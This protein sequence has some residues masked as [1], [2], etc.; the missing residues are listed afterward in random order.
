M[1]NTKVIP[2]RVPAV[3]RFLLQ[4][5]LLSSV[6]QPHDKPLAALCSICSVLHWLWQDN[7]L[8]AIT[9]GGHQTAW[10]EEK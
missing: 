3:K 7:K 10:Q 2:D 8:P 5:E 4:T 1:Y 6:I 9:A